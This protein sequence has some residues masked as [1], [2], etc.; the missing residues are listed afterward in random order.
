M[1]REIFSLQ[2][3]ARERSTRYTCNTKFCVVCLCS[4]F[5]PC[6][7]HVYIEVCVA[8]LH[9]LFTPD[10]L[11]F[12]WFVWAVL[13]LCSCTKSINDIFMPVLIISY[14]DIRSLCRQT[15]PLF[16]ICYDK[17]SYS[18]KGCPSS[19]IFRTNIMD[20]FRTFHNYKRHSST[21]NLTPMEK[22]Y[23]STWPSRSRRSPHGTERTTIHSMRHVDQTPFR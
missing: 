22:K 10:N 18:K 20:R 23:E 7:S 15:K 1:K 14:H 21:V 2:H 9:D 13:V 19:T 17:F 5:G 4:D 12:I 11:L 16:L 6:V 3:R 8:D